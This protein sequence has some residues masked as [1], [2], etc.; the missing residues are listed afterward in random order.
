MRTPGKNKIVNVYGTDGIYEYSYFD[1][2]DDDRMVCVKHYITPDQLEVI[3]NG[4]YLHRLAKEAE[5]AT[6]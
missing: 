3:V 6:I 5:P 4:S 1:T 2:G